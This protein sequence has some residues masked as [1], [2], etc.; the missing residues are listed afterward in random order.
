MSLSRAHTAP[1]PDAHQ[2]EAGRFARWL[3]RATV[4]SLFLL[5]LCAPHSI[6]ATQS[7]WLLAM[8]FWA[9]RFLFR[10]RPRTY[11]TPVDY[12]LLGFFILTFVSAL[13]SYEPDLSIGKLRAASLFTV[14]YVVAENV[15]DRRVLRALAL[16]LVASCAL[17]AVYAFGAYAAGRGVK[18][19]ALAAE[20]PLRAVGLIEGDTLLSADGAN[21]AEPADLVRALEARGA[22]GRPVRVQLYRVELLPEAE[23]RRE[24]LL[25]GATPEARLGIHGWSYGRDQRATGLLGHYTTYAEALQL[26]AS[27]ALGML[28]AL[29]DKRSR[30]G[31]LLALAAA[32]MCGALI[33]TVT[34]A[35]WLGFL[36]S[37]FTIA[38]VG[39]RRRTLVVTAA[40]ALP[41]AAAGL[42]VLQQKRQVGF[43]DTKE[44][45]TSWRLLVWR[46]G[47]DI[48]T[49]SPRHLAVGVGMDTL[50][51]RWREWGMFDHGRQPW[52]H[53]HSTP[54]QLA[55]ERGLPALLAWLALLYLYARALWR[56]ARGGAGGDRVVRGLALGALGGLVGFF[57]SGLVHYNLGDSEVVEIF[58]FVMG[59][60]LAA[61]RLSASGRAGARSVVRGEESGNRG[62]R[63]GV[64]EDED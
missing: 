13:C 38:L 49:S 31:A 41:L 5:A 8:A 28:V 18:L 23:L 59:L 36:L 26:I 40:L 12:A 57:V 1:T 30:R 56:L 46:E 39:A 52:G 25:A 29:R 16:T 47:F 53:L 42:F 48:L 50:K 7:A 20:S 58:Y 27:L 15:T 60:A 55:F 22:G 9:S 45:S 10:P 6:A 43:I 17:S 61:E 35:A 14:V 11:R 3:E 32:L 54:L 24:S 62:R 64:D 2:T 4:A 34:R 33:L 44:G 63:R 37:A 51:R 19:D 21:I